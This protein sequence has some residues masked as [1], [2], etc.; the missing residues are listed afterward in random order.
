M[1]RIRRFGVYQTAKVAAIIY[2][3]FGLIMV[4]MLNSVFLGKWL[5]ES[6]ISGIFF[7]FIPFIYGIIGF[8]FTA[9]F[10]AIYNF[11]VRW[12]GGIEVEFETT[13]E[14]IS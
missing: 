1:K 14:Q 10:C 2:F 9:A 8:M 11:T 3:L 5:P 13:E 6:A 12:T 7:L 4:G